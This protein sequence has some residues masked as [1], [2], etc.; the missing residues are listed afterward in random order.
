MGT[1]VRHNWEERFENVDRDDP[2]R[3]TFGGFG[4]Y[5]QPTLHRVVRISLTM[6]T[7]LLIGVG[8][9]SWVSG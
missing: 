5:K 6:V 2:T 7:L 9:V 8:V 3:S 1:I 4:P